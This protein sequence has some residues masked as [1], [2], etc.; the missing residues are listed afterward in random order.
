MIAKR[1]AGEKDFV[2]EPM[3]HEHR[4][5]FPQ[6]WNWF[7]AQQTRKQAASIELL[8]GISP[9]ELAELRELKLT[10][11]DALADA[12][13]P[14]E[15]EPWRALALRFRTLSKPRMRLV[16]GAMVAA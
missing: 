5:M 6:A 1:N 16:D 3:T 13:V 4:A 8:P 10:D 12:A 11:L 7:Q 15:L 9:A 14:V 2:S